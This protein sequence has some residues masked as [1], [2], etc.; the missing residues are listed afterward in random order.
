[1]A[2]G[3]G[4][5]K[6]K[7]IISGNSMDGD[8]KDALN[9]MFEQM[10]G[11]TNAEP[12][13]ILPKIVDIYV[14]AIKFAKI[15]N[16][17]ISLNNLF[18]FEEFPEWKTEIETFIKNTIGDLELNLDT[19]PT[20]NTFQ[21]LNADEL[22]AL[23]QKLKSNEYIK[24]MIIS[25][26]KL[27]QYKV[28]LTDMNNLNDGFIMQEPGLTLEVLPFTSLDLKLIW[29]LDNVD[30]GL[31]KLILSVMGHTYKIGFELYDLIT[32]PNIDIKK[33]SH[34]II[35]SISQLRKQIPR[36]DLA[37]DVI[38]NS[39][40][41]LENKF[42]TYY[43]NSVEAENPSIIIESF[44]VDVSESQRASPLVTQQFRKIVQVLQQ[45][46]SANKD[47]KVKKL[48]SML[49]SK[50]GELNKELGVQPKSR[51]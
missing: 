25:G 7:K 11:S 38:E 42:K 41:L 49:N 6:V 8:D 32:S 23:F 18:I 28:N 35:S 46:N 33:F 3:K 13:I 22:N 43:K 19:P 40:N 27:A 24:T 15:Y 30:A 45:Q 34:I 4:Q 1:M 48:F 36:C 21:H 39:I 9:K 10:T 12:E 44:I 29:T 37:F 17:F 20:R 47:P 26:S 50:F 31:K 51:T 14:R 5:V 2:R 16:M